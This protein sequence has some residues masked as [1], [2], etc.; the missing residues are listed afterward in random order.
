MQIETALVLQLIESEVNYTFQIYLTA[1]EVF[2][3]L[4]R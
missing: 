3:L 2:S 1:A 4:T